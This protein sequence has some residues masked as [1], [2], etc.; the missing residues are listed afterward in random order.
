MEILQNKVQEKLG[1]DRYKHSLN[2]LETALKLAKYYNIPEEEVQIAALLHDYAKELTL[3]E[4]KKLG[5]EHDFSNEDNFKMYMNLIHGELASLL[6]KSDFGIED[7]DILN[8]IRYHTTG[9]E[10]MSILEKIIYLADVIEPSRDFDKL[11]S[12]REMAY[13][14]L[15]KAILMAMD[16]TLDYLIKTGSLIHI[17]T[18]KARNYIITEIT[19]RL[20]DE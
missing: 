12:I 20:I 14:N 13:V 5:V 6:A 8:A 18:I 3:D 17:D 15:D 1:E 9:R 11:N 19:K 4:V 10:N 2:V 7:I 16:S